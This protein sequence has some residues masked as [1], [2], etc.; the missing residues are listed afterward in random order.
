[1]AQAFFY[2]VY[3]V[4]DIDFCFEFTVA[5]DIPQGF[6]KIIDT[7]ADIEFTIKNILNAVKAIAAVAVVCI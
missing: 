4:D 6:A 2:V 3:P 5:A 1:L 7:P